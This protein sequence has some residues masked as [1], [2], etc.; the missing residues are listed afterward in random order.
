M[1][2]KK[3]TGA[4]KRTLERAKALPDQPWRCMGCGAPVVPGARTPCRC[5]GFDK[6]T[7]KESA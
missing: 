2:A 3:L 5:P 6:Q 4:A 7:L 1:T